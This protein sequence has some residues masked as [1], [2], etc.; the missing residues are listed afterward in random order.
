MCANMVIQ[1]FLYLQV[2]TKT[3]KYI[4]MYI[5]VCACRKYILL[6][7]QGAYKCD[8]HYLCPQTN[9]QRQVIHSVG[10]LPPPTPCSN[11]A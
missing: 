7:F 1:L 9:I 3:V 8:V 5:R 4:N 6:N 10:H 11:A 2:Y